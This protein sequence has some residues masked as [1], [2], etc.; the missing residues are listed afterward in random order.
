MQTKHATNRGALQATETGVASAN[1][2][3]CD[4]SLSVRRASQWNHD[5]FAGDRVLDFDGITYRPNVRISR[6]HLL[7]DTNAAA[8][9]EP[10]PGRL[11]KV[12]LRSNADRQDYKVARV[13]PLRILCSLESDRCATGIRRQRRLTQ[14]DPVLFKMFLNG[15]CHFGIK[16]RHYLSKHLEDCYRKTPMHE[17]LRHFNPIKPAPT[18]TALCAFFS[19]IQA[20]IFRLSGMVRRTRDS[21]ESTPGK[22]PCSCGAGASRRAS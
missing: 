19:L 13:L 20:R 9:A 7:I 21:G 18:M 2:I 6:A 16:R 22:G 10:E 8:V 14:V 17:V 12:R 3:C 1:G 5:P 11:G 15:P 4:P